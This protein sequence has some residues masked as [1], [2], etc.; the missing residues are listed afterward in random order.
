M[1][2]NKAALAAAMAALAFGGCAAA[3]SAAV[4]APTAPAEPLSVFGQRSVLE[5][6]PA[7][8]AATNAPPGTV[9]MARKQPSLANDTRYGLVGGLWTRDVSRAHR[10][11]ARI[12]NGL[13]SV[14]TFRP[15]HFMLPMA[16]IR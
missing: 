6:G 15:V 11:A 7:L 12:E 9:V 14:N 16:G 8:L 5:F 10:V 3:P 13:V 2:G 1:R 4:N